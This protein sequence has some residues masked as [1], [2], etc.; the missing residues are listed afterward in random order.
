MKHA[1]LRPTSDGRAAAS[2]DSTTL[3]PC[4]SSRRTLPS[5]QLMVPTC[6]FGASRPWYCGS[7]AT[8]SCSLAVIFA[9]VSSSTGRWTS[10]ETKAPNFCPPSSRSWPYSTNRRASPPSGSRAKVGCSGRMKNVVSLS[11]DP[12]TEWPSMVWMFSSSSMV[13]VPSP[14]GD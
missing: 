7:A 13:I 3:P 14:R 2:M 6:T 9:M 10:K 8:C 1:T 12:W 11:V 5:S 4:L